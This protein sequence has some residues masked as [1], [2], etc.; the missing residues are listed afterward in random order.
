MF[1]YGSIKRT[2]YFIVMLAMLPALAIILY[3]GLDSRQAAL[4]ET[5][6]KASDLM[7]NVITQQELWTENS[8]MLLLTLTQLSE[9]RQMEADPC[10]VLLQDIRAN[11]PVYANFALINAKGKVVAAANALNG[12]EEADFSQTDI[13]KKTLSSRN[14]TVGKIL[15]DP[16]SGRRVL[17]YAV[18]VMDN[19]GKVMA[20]LLA[21]LKAER[22]IFDFVNK[23]GALL[24]GA[25]I[26]ILDASGRIFLSYPADSKAQNG[27]LSVSPNWEHIRKG[28]KPAGYFDLISKDRQKNFVAYRC[29]SLRGLEAPYFSIEMT[30]SE[31]TAYAKANLLLARNVLL[32]FLASAL[33]F[34]IAWLMERAALVKPVNKLLRATSEL[35][36]G[37]LEA[38]TS[39]RGLTGEIGLL[40]STFDEM[41]DALEARD[42]DLV[43]AKRSADAANQAKSDFLTNMSHEI[44]TP[45][46]SIIGMAYLA[47]KSNLNPKQYS[48]V[49]K[50]Y[51][52]A[53]TL[54]GI[55]N[56]ILD[57]SKIES[58][59]LNIEQVQFSLDEMLD[60]TAMLISQKA[61]EKGLE[62]LFGIS[63]DVPQNLVGDPLRLGQVLTNLTNN[64]VKFTEQGEI[65]IY[66]ELASRF[67]NKVRLRFS[68]KDTGIGMT[69]EQQEKLFQPFTQADGS[70]TRK[71]GGTGLGLT[72]TKKILEL[73][74]GT[75]NIE[76]EFGFG[77]TVIFT[78]CFTLPEV[79]RETVSRHADSAANLM[80]GTKIL[81]VDDS[82]EAGK[83]FENLLSS[84]QFRVSRVTSPSEAFVL[85]W[86]HDA[87]DPFKAVFMDWRMPSM[88]G[89]EATYRLRTELNLANVPAVLITST[90]NRPEIAQQANKAGAA[91]VIY[92]PV[93]KSLLYDALLAVLNKDPDSFRQHLAQE[94]K[95]EIA[96]LPDLS[97]FSILLVE[98]NP[99]N[100]QMA[101]D[102]LSSAGAK[103]TVAGNGLE[104]L[105]SLRAKQ[106]EKPGAPPFDLTLMDLKMPEMDGY[107]AAKAIREQER[108]N[109][110]P[111]VAMTA[112]VMP[113]ER[114]RCLDAGMNDHISKP[115]EVDKF[116][117][118]LELWLKKLDLNAADPATRSARTAQAFQE[119]EPS[120]GLGAHPMEGG[121][122]MVKIELFNREQPDP[123]RQTN[124]QAQEPPAGRVQ[125]RRGGPTPVTAPPAKG[126]TPK[127]ALTK[128]GADKKLVPETAGP[129]QAQPAP[130]PPR[131]PLPQNSASGLP[132][133]PGLNVQTAL[134]RLGN[135][136]K[137]YRKLLEQFVDFYK[138]IPVEYANA[139]GKED[140]GEASRIAHTL[141]GLAASLGADALSRSAADLESA[142][143]QSGLDHA[144]LAE[145]CFAELAIV[146]S[147]LRKAL[148][149][150][151]AENSPREE[152]AAPQTD[153]PAFDATQL[154]LLRKLHD[155]LEDDDAQADSFMQAHMEE[156]KTMLPGTEF[157]ALKLGVSRFDF[158]K[159]LEILQKYL[160]CA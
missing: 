44:R 92:K 17:P 138:D 34:V 90:V 74:D 23:E 151:E 131:Q 93:N 41:A 140:N 3:S 146:Q 71:F 106:P 19:E 152:C 33:A 5:R 29:L 14:F 43:R 113:E 104:A 155:F 20:V 32:L 144:E 136:E 87:E 79:E 30:V 142:H 39:V 35:S 75:I 141:K 156:F 63:P 97:G 48:Y 13:F 117:A 73:M 143:K 114:Q 158:E 64:A 139:V 159:A 62:V 53:N 84:L 154:D 50:I 80:V 68:V 11:Y 7:N 82:E 135:N 83:M 111:I 46:N 36:A 78:A 130:E 49:S 22:E 88:D 132:P 40:A 58:G 129:E 134:A 16:L 72:I 42:H 112:H 149:M 122:P 107:D 127:T 96:A 108:Y 126:E 81:V 89:V 69:K 66:C 86:Q 37:N 21:G 116:F 98:D 76:S 148:N 128:T 133:L 25:T 101:V 147:M 119:T 121:I 100:Q 4:E 8:R 28:N 1:F 94:R 77:T 12:K 47:L 124:A 105:R 123:A 102:L 10:T 125:N 54:L 31:S 18:P 70:T 45:M 57:F 15:E 6:E 150:P 56:D 59:Q 27:V 160:G 26:S 157:N 65:I 118:T 61:E 38:R 110:M 60:S 137:I 109:N 55:I 52:A 91:G 67:G 153:A 120:P 85:L 51:A 95:P 115:L 145:T 2:L 103:V 24:N 99:I 9:V